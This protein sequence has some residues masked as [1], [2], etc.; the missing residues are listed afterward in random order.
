MFFASCGSLDIISTGGVYAF[1][2]GLPTA[3]R[4]IVMMTVRFP[5]R[6]SVLITDDDE[7]HRDE[8]CSELEPEGYDTVVADCGLD[9]VKIVRRQRIH[10]VIIEMYMPEMTGVETLRLI[11]DTV[12]EPPP[13]ILVSRDVTKELMLRALRAHAHTLLHKPVDL[14]LTRLILEKLIRRTYL[15]QAAGGG[16]TR[17]TKLDRQAGEH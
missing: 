4:I 15:A 8:L 16:A 12:G 14:R 2:L 9:A 11:E 6:Y 17:G 7:A 5:G 13:S 10:V 3:G 1:I